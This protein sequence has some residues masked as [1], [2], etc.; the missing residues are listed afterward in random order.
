MIATSHAE[1]TSFQQQGVNILTWGAGLQLLGM[2]LELGV[3]C[4]VWRAARGQGCGCGGWGRS[5]GCGE[6]T[7]A[8]A[9][10]DSNVERDVEMD[11]EMD[12]DI[13]TDAGDESCRKGRVVRLGEFPVTFSISPSIPLST[14][15]PP[16]QGNVR[17][18]L[19]LR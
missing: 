15:F 13:E 2:A 19:Y 18:N 9:D 16:R 4:C 7:D 8:K 6:C 5:L 12:T 14:R 1:G 17:L 10:V 11:V 3:F